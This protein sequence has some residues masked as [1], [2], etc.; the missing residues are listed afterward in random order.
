MN[1]KLCVKYAV[2]TSIIFFMFFSSYYLWHT[3]MYLK[4]ERRVAATINIVRL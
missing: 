3:K 1:F 2:W 4:V